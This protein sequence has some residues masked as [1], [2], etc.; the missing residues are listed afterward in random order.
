MINKLWEL[1]ISKLP[2]SS[3][4]PTGSYYRGGQHHSKR[5]GPF[6]IRAAD[7]PQKRGGPFDIGA[8]NTTQKRGGPFDI[9]AANTTQKDVVPLI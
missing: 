6:D 5:R 1:W 4:N 3:G 8:A 7:T 2:I 9:G